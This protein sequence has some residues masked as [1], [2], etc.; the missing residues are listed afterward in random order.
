LQPLVASV[1]L[2][3]IA[4]LEGFMPRILKLAGVQIALVAMLLRA[5]LPVDW[6]PGAADNA[7][8]S[9]VICTV[10]GPVHAAHGPDGQKHNQDDGR[11][12]D[13]C[14]FAASVHLATPAAVA[15]IAP[16]T[17]VASFT[18]V[19]SPAPAVRAAMRYAFPSPRAPPSLV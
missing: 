19:P 3:E 11:Q 4:G 9:F 13:V 16:S 7:A 8:A 18:P 2:A 5:I 1:G 6:M 14:P 10:N 12:N 17:Q 15:S